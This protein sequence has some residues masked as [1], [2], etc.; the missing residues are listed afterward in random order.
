MVRIGAASVND[1]GAKSGPGPSGRPCKRKNKFGL[2]H[3]FVQP[4]P[5][6]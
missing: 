4:D 5:I 2:K 1:Y 6:Q 3:A